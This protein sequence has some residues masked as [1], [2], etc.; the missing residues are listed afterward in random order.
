MFLL[1]Y[2]DKYI[3]NVFYS[4]SMDH[5][6]DD[7]DYDEEDFNVY[8]FLMISQYQLGIS[9]QLIRAKGEPGHVFEIS[10]CVDIGK[11][12]TIYFVWKSMCFVAYVMH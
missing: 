1:T 7:T 12:V 5:C 8:V 6:R 11:D 2:F 9:K 4:G 3:L 10:S